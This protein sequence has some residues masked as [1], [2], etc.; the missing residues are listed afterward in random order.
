MA[1]LTGEALGL[2]PATRVSNK[3]VGAGKISVILSGP[4]NYG[5]GASSFKAESGHGAEDLEGEAKVYF[6]KLAERAGSRGNS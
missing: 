4:P 5:P 3:T 1:L 6:R 2:E